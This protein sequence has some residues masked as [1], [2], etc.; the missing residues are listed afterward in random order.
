MNKNNWDLSKV[1]DKPTPKRVVEN[2]I[3]AIPLY[4][5]DK[6][7]EILYQQADDKEFHYC[8]LF[9][10]Q[11]GTGKTGLLQSYPLKDNEKHIILDLDGGN[12]PILQTYHKDKINNIIVHNPLVTTNTSEG[13]KTIDFKETMNKIKWIVDYVRR[14][15]KEDNIKAI[16][17]DGLSKLLK[18]AEGMMRIDKHITSDGGVEYRFWKIRNEAFIEIIEIM[19]SIPI[20]KFF[21]A[22]DD[23][24]IF[25]DNLSEEISKVKLETNRMMYQKVRCKRKKDKENVEYKCIIDKSK[26][27]A[28]AE[29]Q[30]L[31]F[32]K[33]NTKEKKYE[34]AGQKLFDL[35]KENGQENK[36]V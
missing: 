4:S 26:Y 31:I 15:Y 27:N 36:K 8:C 21:V 22:H 17:I 1:E 10:G 7:R 6:I 28:K 35:L 12:I 25:E 19:K 14:K 32:L 13:M 16:S 20:D 33:I 24:I 29:G 18:F 2:S 9:Y 5:D 3:K 30:E 34:W 23:F 11:D